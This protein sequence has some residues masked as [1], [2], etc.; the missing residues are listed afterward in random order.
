VRETE[1]AARVERS[2]RRRGP[3]RVAIVGVA[4]VVVVMAVAQVVGPAIAARVVRGRVARYGTVKSVTVKA[5]PAVTLL[6]RVADEVSVRAGRLT[7]TPQQTVGLLKEARGTKRV[8]AWAESVEEG[9]LRLREA[10]L[11]KDGSALRARGLVSEEAVR[12][13]LPAGVQVKLLKS[14]RGMVEVRVSG[15][16]FGMNAS[17]EAVGKAE[18]GKLVVR[19]VGLLGGLRVTIF[20]NPDVYVEGVEARAVEGEENGEGRRYE[21]EMWASLR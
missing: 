12:R 19:P 16:L 4:T 17:V 1:D 9:P 21:L 13:A 6:W 15:G 2:K 7:L 14:E 5:W 11:E 3:V 10:R 8:S 20:E 18:D